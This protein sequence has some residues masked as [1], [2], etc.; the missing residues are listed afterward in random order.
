MS[1][2]LE[3]SMPTE[4]RGRILEGLHGLPGVA[5]IALQAGASV[6][7]PG[8][9]ICVEATNEASLKILKMLDEMEAFTRGSITLSEPTAIIAPPHLAE[10]DRQ[11]SEAAWEEVG[12][13]LRRGTNVSGN[14]LLLM[15]LSGMI[16]AFGLTSDTLHVVVGAMLIAPGFEPLLR[17]PFEAMGRQRIP[18]G[19]LLS[20]LA[21]YLA[22]VAGAAAAL[23]AAL[24]LT[25]R[26]TAEL[27]ALQW[28]QYWSSIQVSGVAVSLLAGA[29][30]AT[31][32]AARLTVFATG[33]MTALALVPSAAL[34]GM[35]LASGHLGLAWAAAQR[36]GIEVLCV[37]FAGGLVIALKRFIWHRRG[38]FD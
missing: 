23:P 24:L 21:G 2:R 36:W 10:L 20:S 16:A 35:G 22:L 5:G 1:R 14:F 37:L 34:V 18:R 4:L 26:E 31:I 27:P 28:V 25:G 6:D 13:Q 15:G 7:P 3:L 8:D 11:G 30:G 33:V 12:E 9:V 32:I 29:A 38:V 17:I 19:G